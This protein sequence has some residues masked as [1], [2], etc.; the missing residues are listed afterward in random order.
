MVNKLY[1]KIF[2]HNYPI[3]YGTRAIWDTN[4]LCLNCKE[5]L[6][7]DITLFCIIMGHRYKFVPT[8]KGKD[9]MMCVKCG[10][11]RDLP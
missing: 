3:P 10:F 6:E 7:E 2:G 8:A 1:C 11:I 5:S 9:Y 4:C